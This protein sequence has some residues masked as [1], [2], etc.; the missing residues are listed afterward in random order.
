MIY[1]GGIVVPLAVFAISAGYPIVYN[2][3]L[4]FTS[5]SG[6]SQHLHSV[7]LNNYIQLVLDPIFLLALLNTLKWTV[8][9][10]VLTLGVALSLS[11]ILFLGNFYW[12]TVFRSLIFVP[13]TMSLVAIGII[14]SLVLSPGFGLLDQFLRA[15]GLSGLVY[16][17]LGDYHTTLYVL[18]LIGVWAYVGIP[19]M[20]FHAGLNEVD[21]DLLDAARLDGANNFQIGRY[22]LL[23]ALKPVIV[24][25]AILSVIQSLKTFDLVAVMT[26]GGPAGATKVLGYFMYIETFWNNRFG[27][28]AAISIIIL[29]LGVG[30]AWIYLRGAAHNALHVSKQ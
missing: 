17:W 3:F 18:I 23:P 24:I 20:L 22:I 30:F 15:V 21:R 25:V 13:A 4:S 16:P 2:L 19:I 26:Q 1:L 11:I 10:L 6:L 28:G 9:S 27:Y 14:F 5:W 12:P 29:L 8:L 7:G